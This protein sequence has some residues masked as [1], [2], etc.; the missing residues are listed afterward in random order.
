MLAG[1]NVFFA[2]VKNGIV[3][4]QF[5]SPVPGEGARAGCEKWVSPGGVFGL[6]RNIRAEK[7]VSWRYLLYLYHGLFCW[8]LKMFWIKSSFHT[9][10][11]NYHL[12]GFEV[13]ET[14]GWVWC[15]F[16][17]GDLCFADNDVTS[18][19]HMMTILMS[20]TSSFFRGISERQFMTRFYCLFVETQALQIFPFLELASS[21]SQI[22]MS[23]SCWIVFCH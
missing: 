3:A 18:C 14:D 1:C 7:A 20:H 15:W 5:G 21:T 6:W 10:H 4:F 13:E 2:R 22:T 17:I 8:H 9:T 23:L 19:F 12:K 16:D 11:T